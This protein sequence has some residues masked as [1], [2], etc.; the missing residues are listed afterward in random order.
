MALFGEPLTDFT[1]RFTYDQ[2]LEAVYKLVEAEYGDLSIQLTPGRAA[3]TGGIGREN[4]DV[5]LRIY[6]GFTF[7]E[8]L[9]RYRVYRAALLFSLRSTSVLD[10][11]ESVGVS[12]ATLQRYTTKYLCMDPKTLRLQ[13]KNQFCRASA[14]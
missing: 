3:A 2:R 6:V 11:A 9:A 14:D 5:L 8:F 7:C 10:V 12:Q 1:R 4:L 13:F